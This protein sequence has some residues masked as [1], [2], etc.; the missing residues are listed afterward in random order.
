MLVTKWR[1]AGNILVTDQEAFGPQ[2]S[3]GGIHIDGI[4]QDDEVDHE[5]EGAKL[6]LLAIA[7]ALAQLPTAPMEDDTG[8]L[9]ALFTPVELDQD[10]P[11]VG[12]VVNVSQQV[13]GLDD[14]AEFRQRL[15]QPGAE[16]PSARKSTLAYWM[17][18]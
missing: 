13:L 16:G 9:V 17:Q 12:L 18:Y 1:Q 15:G 8:E 14:A 2:L 7:V 6:V 5:A 10:A 11:A 4:P 3:Q